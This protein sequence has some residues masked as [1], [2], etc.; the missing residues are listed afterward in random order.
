MYSE[1]WNFW[2]TFFTFFE[3]PLQ[4]NAFF[5]ISKKNVKYVFSNVCQ[6]SETH[7]TGRRP[8]RWSPA[9]RDTWCRRHSEP[10]PPSTTE[11]TCLWRHQPRSLPAPG[12]VTRPPATSRTADTGSR[13]PTVTSSSFRQATSGLINTG[14]PHKNRKF[15]RYNIFA[16]TTDIILRC[17]LYRSVQKLQQKTTCDF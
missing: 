5:G 12:H 16:A 10:A 13:F 1:S 14:W 15:L 2:I 11:T 3:M 9:E 17:G 7:L 6:D 8:C 4:K